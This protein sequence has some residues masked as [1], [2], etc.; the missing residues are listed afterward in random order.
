MHASDHEIFAYAAR[1]WTCALTMKEF[2]ALKVHLDNLHLDGKLGFPGGRM[3]RARDISD[4]RKNINTEG[5]R[6][7]VSEMEAVAK[8]AL[9]AAGVPITRMRTRQQP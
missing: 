2:E 5:H 4:L 6:R 8:F 3:K 7:E 9:E 1:T